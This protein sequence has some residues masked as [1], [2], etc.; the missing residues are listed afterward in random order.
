[1]SESP[2]LLSSGKID[3]RNQIICRKPIHFVMQVYEEEM[4]DALGGMPM[5]LY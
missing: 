1:M 4:V 2:R 5:Q 3:K